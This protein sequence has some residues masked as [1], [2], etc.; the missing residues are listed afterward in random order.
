MIKSR[1]KILLILL[2]LMLL[3]VIP[4]SYADGINE[5]TKNN[6]V[7]ENNLNSI[8]ISSDGNDISGYGSQSNPYLTISKAVEVY[9]SSSNS[10]IVIKNGKYNITKPIELNKDITISGESKEGVI[11]NGN[12]QSAIIEISNK[13]NVFLNNITFYKWF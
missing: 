1:K 3:I 8:Y 11:L 13:A 4:N 10:D 7:T 9:N 5:T 12:K 2:M 6:A